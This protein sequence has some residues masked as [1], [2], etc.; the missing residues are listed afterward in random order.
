MDLSGA[1]D[2]GVHT[3]P[4]ASGS[5]RRGESQEVFIEHSTEQR[6]ERA[7]VGFVCCFEDRL[8]QPFLTLRRSEHA[9]HVGPPVLP[10]GAQQAHDDVAT[11]DADAVLAVADLHERLEHGVAH[12]VTDV[13]RSR[14]QLPGSADRERAVHRPAVLEPEVRGPRGNPR[15]VA[16]ERAERL[17]E[18]AESPAPSLAA[19]LGMARRAEGHAAP[20]RR[21]GLG[22]GV[23]PPPREHGPD[24]RV[25]RHHHRCEVVVRER[26]QLLRRRRHASKELDRT[27]V[28]RRLLL[29]HRRSD[30][31][32]L[33]R[34]TFGT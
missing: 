17:Q 31:S 24:L 21:V 30:R 25:Q 16:I 28:V 27:R 6:V 13:D 15:D 11:H 1:V 10:I 18:E 14:E 23:D 32:K 19:D 3:D 5:H 12:V 9:Q 26:V 2:V 7:R 33:D 29:Q 34:Q 8:A 20:A 22:L 4:Q